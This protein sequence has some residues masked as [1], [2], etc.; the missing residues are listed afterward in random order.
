MADEYL[1]GKLLKVA[2]D[3]ATFGVRDLRNPDLSPF[4]AGPAIPDA[5]VPAGLV[6]VQSEHQ[7]AEIVPISAN[8]FA[9]QAGDP[10]Q[11]FFVDFLNAA[12]VET[13]FTRDITV[14]PAD[15]VLP[16][17]GFRTAFIKEQSSDTPLSISDIR[18]KIRS[19]AF[20]ARSD[21]QHLA[22]PDPLVVADSDAFVRPKLRGMR[23]YAAR[24]LST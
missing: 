1:A 16:A 11:R 3:M 17:L 15:E 21:V 4:F 22:Q 20:V 14:T 7:E 10:S 24:Y 9:E 23:N 13:T 6:A 18:S 19:R 5:G 12:G 2:I 8:A